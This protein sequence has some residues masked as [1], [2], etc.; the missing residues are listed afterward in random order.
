MHSRQINEH[1]PRSRWVQCDCKN[2]KPTGK[3]RVSKRVGDIIDK[4]EEKYRE[5]VL[6]VDYTEKCRQRGDTLN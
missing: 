6:E 2:K 4:I 3:S 5:E 1:G